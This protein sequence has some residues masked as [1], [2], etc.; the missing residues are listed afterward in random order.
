M[1]ALL[2]ECA[3]PAGDGAPIV[4]VGAGPVGVRAAQELAR[5]APERRIL[6]YG[7]EPR[8]PYNRV[9]L[10][11]FL[12]GELE[13]AAITTNLKLPET[14]NIETRFGCAVVTLDRKGHRLWDALNR[15]QHYRKLVLAT[16][17]RPHVP[18]IPGIDLPGVYTFRDM[19]DALKLFAR[20]ARSR[21]TV[22]LGGG[23]LGLEAARAMQK[24]NTEVCVI[25]HSDRLM[26]R[27][28]DEDAARVLRSRVETMGIEVILG[29]GAK[30]IVGPYSVKGVHLRND[31]IVACDTVIVAT[32]IRPNIRLALKAG[33]SVGRGIRVNDR[34]QTS[35]PDVYAVGEC[36]E[37]RDKIYGFV[38]PG[39]EQAAV[40]VHSMLDGVAHYA[41]TFAAT[42]LKVLDTPVFSMGRIGEDSPHPAGHWVYQSADRNVYRKLVLDRGRLAGA[43]AIGDWAELGRIQEALTHG[44]RVWPWQLWRFRRQGS[45]W[46]QAE[47][48][49][50]AHWP[51]A[52][53]VCNCTGVTRGQLAE[54]LADGCRSV[55]QLATR[56]GASLACGSCRP[57]LAELAGERVA[58]EPRRGRKP[59][60]GAV[61]ATL[62]FSLL[63]IFAPAIPYA[64]SVDVPWQ[65]DRLWREILWKQASGFTLLGLAL[66]ALLMSLRKRWSR[67]RL[68][69]FAIWRVLHTILG[70][71]VLV[72]LPVHTGGRLGS[73]LNLLLMVCF[74]GLMLVGGVAAAVIGLEYRIAPGIAQKMRGNWAWAHILLFWPVP[75]LLA[76]HIL[77]TY[78]F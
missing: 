53:T 47:T 23:L 26:A 74:L 66:L 50:V 43:I 29:N 40:A 17:S 30:R 14:A 32:G 65:W 41:G 45:V 71:G 55:E 59:L 22:V 76:F 13:W 42:R 68:G 52:V 63:L 46:P 62:L 2:D 5:R 75:V 78:Y 4:V 31:R 6:I 9:R 16:G 51:A 61:L 25:E 3:I 1:A 20:K 24:F 33:I 38:A 7:D 34:M 64:H 58:P 21:R 56:T 77:K 57:L 39:F 49:S 27:Q 72:A 69:D 36:A 54:A 67:F 73:Q 18:E 10:S 35:D 19:D 12:A 70:V 15:A 44:R 37:H 60:L 8:E 28:L 11:S 48:A